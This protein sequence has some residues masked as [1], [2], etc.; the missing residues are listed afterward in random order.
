MKIDCKRLMKSKI[1]SPLAFPPKRN[2]QKETIDLSLITFQ[3]PS[4]LAIR[5]PTAAFK[6]RIA[7]PPSLS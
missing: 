5:I 7:G 1:K 4:R 2:K 6:D 3:S